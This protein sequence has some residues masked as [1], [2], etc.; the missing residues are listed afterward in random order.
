MQVRLKKT[1]E[2]EVRD[3]CIKWAKSKGWLHIRLHFG[4]G[5]ARGW[6]DDVF[7]R[8][9][10]HVWVEFKRPG[11]KPTKLQEL[12]HVALY[13]AGAEVYVVDSLSDFLWAMPY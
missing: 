7:I 8:D 5:A 12:R 1:T 4:K 6:P 2:K 3:A 9:G 11:A 10:R 13:N